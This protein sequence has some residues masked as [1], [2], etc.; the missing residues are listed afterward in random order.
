MKN[1]QT[2]CEPLVHRIKIDKGP[3]VVSFPLIRLLT[4]ESTQFLTLKEK[5]KINLD[6]DAIIIITLYILS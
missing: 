4:F 6:D 5:W 3:V 2:D 1:N